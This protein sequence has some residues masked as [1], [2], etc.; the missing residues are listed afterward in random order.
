MCAAVH[1]SP[2]WDEGAVVEKASSFASLYALPVH[3][4]PGSSVDFVWQ[5][6]PF[7]TDISVRRLIL[8]PLATHPRLS[9]IVI[10]PGN[11]LIES[12]GVDFLLPF[13]MAVYLGVIPAQPV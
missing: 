2:S 5:R 8:G 4:R 7:A 10:N 13:W 12:A 11:K 1:R 6:S 9:D 3:K